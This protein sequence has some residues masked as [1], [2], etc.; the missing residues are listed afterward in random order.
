MDLAANLLRESNAAIV[1][2][3]ARVGYES[4]IAHWVR[5]FSKFGLL[6]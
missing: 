2:I 5:R 1:S 6:S 4:E 3:A